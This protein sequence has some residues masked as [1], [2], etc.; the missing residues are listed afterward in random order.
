MK[1]ITLLVLLLIVSIKTQANN[2]RYRLVITDDPA[3]TITIGWDQ[4]SGINPIVY[5]D[6]IDYGINFNNYAYNKAVER[7]RTYKSMN[8]NFVKLTELTPNT[9][10][11]FVIKDSEGTSNRFWF[12]TAPSTNEAMSFIAGGD[13]RN[14]IVPRQNANLLVSKLKPTAVF[15]GGDMTNR[16][17]GSEWIEWFNHWQLTTSADGRMIPIVPTRGNHEDSNES[18]YHLFNTP[19]TD[20]YYDITFGN[21]LYTIFTLNSEMTAGGNQAI[22]LEEKLSTE[23]SIWKSAQYHK[24]MRP[25][26]GSKSEGNDEYNNWAQL[27]YDYGVDL[28]YESDSHNVKSTYPIKPCNGSTNCDEGFEID[29]D[30]GTVYVGEGCWGAPLRSN[31]D[32]KSWTRNSGSFNQ[33]KWITVST[34]EITIKTI[35]V[36]NAASVGENSNHEIPGALPTGTQVWNPSNGDTIV[37]TNNITTHIA[38]IAA[39]QDVEEQTDGTV[40]ISSSDLEFVFDG[41]SNQTIGMEFANVSIPKG[42]T[43]SKAY[44]QFTSDATDSDP[45]D[46]LVSVEDT[47]NAEPL[48]NSN[49]SVTSR[50]YLS[51][52]LWSPEPWTT[53]ASGTAERTSDLTHSIQTIVGNASW[54]NGNSVVIKI[55]ATPDYLGLTNENRRASSIEQGNGPIL[56]LEYTESPNE[57]PIIEITSHVHNDYIADGNDVTFTANAS[58]ADGTITSVEFFVNETSIGLYTSQ[59]YT[60]STT[61]PDG[62]NSLKATSTDDQGATNSKAITILVGDFTSTIALNASQDVEQQ[63]DGS[64]NATSSDLE[65]VYDGAYVKGDQTIGIEFSN[66]AIP[67]G[68]IITSAYIQFTADATDSLPLD[69]LI[70]IEDNAKPEKLTTA[71]YGVTSRTYLNAVLWS[72]EPWTNNASGEAERT[73]D[74][75]SSI[76]TILSKSLW[77]IDNSIVVKIEATPDYLGFTDERRRADSVDKGNHPVLHIIYEINSES[78]NIEDVVNNSEQVVLYPNPAHEV[79]NIKSHTIFHLAEFYALSGKLVL[80]TKVNNNKIL[81]K[82]LQS[83]VYIIKLSVP[84]SNYKIIKKVIIN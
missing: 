20:I 55:E 29:N 27:F 66:V 17:S 19:S 10:Y 39:N 50:T 47:A 57:F 80:I 81:I 14:N 62:I 18:I 48:T 46:L 41:G 22:W 16:D 70:S 72:P 83:G 12:K 43:I 36:D 78:L 9:A 2:D 79:I 60:I 13:S 59:P 77:A 24:P 6:T 64:V 65:F 37:I 76:Q 68:A 56:H 1:K 3:T 69:L 45:I 52:I 67:S 35:M 40:D 61:L 21:N 4:T 51:P 34:T 7:V 38:N 73:P 44:I 58:D 53:G 75:T 74:L 63:I 32:D 30:N 71:N 26:A 54:A 49:N 33:F 42:A 5:Y 31:N 28:V 15:F 8:N 84:N 11:Y 25:H 82:K 23:N